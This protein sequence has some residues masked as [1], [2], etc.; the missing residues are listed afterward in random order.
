MVSWGPGREVCTRDV[1]TYLQTLLLLKTYLRPPEAAEGG[2]RGLV[3][4][5]DAPPRPQRGPAVAVVEVE[6]RAVGHR[7]GQVQAGMC[8]GVC[9]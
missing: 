9:V 8:G 7:A 4:A 6:E 1:R 5:D 3:R 2:V